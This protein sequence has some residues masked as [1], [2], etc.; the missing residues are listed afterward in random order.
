MNDTPFL[1][2]ARD[3]CKQDSPHSF[4]LVSCLIVQKAL[5]DPQ[6]S[7]GDPNL[8][9][10]FCP[11]SFFTP[12]FFCFV[13]TFVF[14]AVYILIFQSR[15]D[16]AVIRKID[17]FH[18]FRRIIDPRE[19]RGDPNLQDPFCPSSFFTPFFFC[20]VLAFV[21]RTVYILIFQSPKDH[22]VI[23]KFENLHF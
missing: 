23:G 6:G 19:N 15:K 10:P 11:S 8:Q 16:H 1:G 12:F 18:F 20:F 22:A 17:S 5:I 3:A 7:R 21:F 4:E 2:E 9:D 14:R 13:V